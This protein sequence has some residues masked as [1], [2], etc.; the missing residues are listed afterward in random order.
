MAS[1]EVIA[2]I[3][4]AVGKPVRFKYPGT[5]G[6]L[7]GTLKQRVV[8]AAGQNVGGVHYWDVIDRIEFGCEGEREF[9][10]IGYYRKPLERLIWGSQTTITEPLSTWRT[11]FIK[12]AQEQEWFRDLLIEVMAEVKQN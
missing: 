3:M 11:L 2:K 6:E 7:N 1:D 10:R 9:M 4:N 8:L 12:A 5:E